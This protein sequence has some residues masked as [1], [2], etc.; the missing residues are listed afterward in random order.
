MSAGPADH[1]KNA[2]DKNTE[3]QLVSGFPAASLR[4]KGVN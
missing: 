4:E 2:H 1:V 3:N